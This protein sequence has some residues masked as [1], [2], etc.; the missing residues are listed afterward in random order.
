M[1]FEILIFNFIFQ[2]LVAYMYDEFLYIDLV[3][4]DHADLTFILIAFL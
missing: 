4:S 1:L 2:L 3:S